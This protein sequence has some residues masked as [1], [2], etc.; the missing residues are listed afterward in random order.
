MNSELCTATRH[1][2]WLKGEAMVRHPETMS[3]L[4]E[5]SPPHGAT[6]SHDMRAA[7]ELHPFATRQQSNS[8]ATAARGD[9][10][11]P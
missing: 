1:S 2:G 5:M 11:Q 4:P 3:Q 6:S 7:F 9:L 8:A 10:R